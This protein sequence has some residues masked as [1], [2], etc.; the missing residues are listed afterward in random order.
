MRNR[1][2]YGNGHRTGVLILQ[3]EDIREIAVVA[4]S[5]E[6]LAGLRLDEL[7]GDAD[8]IARLA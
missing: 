7:P 1:R 6:V 5:P 3:R 2:R 8:A 4:L